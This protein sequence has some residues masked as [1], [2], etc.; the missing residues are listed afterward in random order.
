VGIVAP[1]PAIALRVATAAADK[2]PLRA[3]K[4]TSLRAPRPPSNTKE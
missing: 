3:S 4:L 1:L 2:E